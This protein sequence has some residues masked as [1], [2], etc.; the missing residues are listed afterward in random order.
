MGP[1]GAEH[2]RAD[3]GRDGD[4]CQRARVDGLLRLVFRLA[5]WSVEASPSGCDH[6]S[7]RYVEQRWMDVHR[8]VFEHRIQSCSI[9]RGFGFQR[10]GSGP[11]GD[12]D[13]A[14]SADHT[15]PP[16]TLR[17]QD[18]DCCDDEGEPQQDRPVCSGPCSGQAQRP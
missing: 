3:Q 11:Y 15:E 13:R 14:N 18:S 5:C 8:P 6:K 17:C 16:S 10:E 12:H 7:L 4:Q 2:G 1:P 9:K